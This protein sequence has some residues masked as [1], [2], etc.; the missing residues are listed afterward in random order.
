[1]GWELVKSAIESPAGSFAF[2]FFVLLLIA[3]LIFMATKY[4]T[5]WSMKMKGVDKLEQK[6]ESISGDLLYVKTKLEIFAAN[7]PGGLTASHSPISLTDRGKEIAEQMGIEQIIATNWDLIYKYISENA[8]SKNA[9]DLQQFC[10]EAATV[11]LD[12]LLC[13][14]DLD[15]IKMFAFNSGQNIAYYGSMIGI[16]IRDKYFAIQG[17]PIGD[18]DTHDPNRK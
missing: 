12:R 16:L 1:M 14:E 13:K 15:K 10:I 11:A 4:T 8:T 7:T 5:Q 17:I 2:V 3:W 18:I 9:Y 6:I